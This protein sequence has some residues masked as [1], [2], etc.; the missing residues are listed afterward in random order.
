MKCD[1]WI[2]ANWPLWVAAPRLDITPR[3]ASG[4]ADVGGT[5]ATRLEGAR[6]GLSA[7]RAAFAAGALGRP[8]LLR[9]QYDGPAPASRCFR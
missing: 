7:Q 6:G 1:I 4:A 3:A 8:A 5:S 9:R 2:R